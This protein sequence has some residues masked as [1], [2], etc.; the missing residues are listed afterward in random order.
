M[1]LNKKLSIF[2]CDFQIATF[3]I[4]SLVFGATFT[5]VPETYWAYSAIENVTA[6]GYLKDLK[7]TTFGPDNYIDKFTTSKIL[8]TVMN[9]VD[10][11]YTA[12]KE[13]ISVYSGKF[14]KWNTDSNNQIAYLLSKNILLDEDIA[15]FMLFSDDGSEKFRAISREEVAVLLVR[16]IGKTDEASKMQNSAF[17]KDN[18]SI[19]E[20]RKGSINYLKSI[21]VLNGDSNGN[22]NPKHAVTKAEFCVLL[23]NVTEKFPI[24]KNTITTPINNVTTVTGT[25]N[26]YYSAL[27]VVQLKVNNEVNTYRLNA[28]VT[29]TLENVETTKDAIVSSLN[30]VALMNNG[31][32]IELKLTKEPVQNTESTSVSDATTETTTLDS[33]TNSKKTLCLDTSAKGTIES[34]ALSNHALAQCEIGIFADSE[35][36]YFTATRYT[37]PIYELKIGDVVSVE[38]KDGKIKTLKFNSKNEK[39]VLTGYI[40]EIDDESVLV[41]SFNSD[42]YEFF[43]DE[44]YTECFDCTTGKKVDFDDLE[45]YSKVYIYYEDVN[46]RIIDVIFVLDN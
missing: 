38:A 41:E 43:Y 25:V 34:I 11:D 31:E 10:G 23:S 44:D 30:A 33:S 16:I 29:V 46:S 21:N 26:E 20:S 22:C 6:K 35:M 19:T 18:A 4:S 7:S 14:K 28:N 42:E 2:L 32:I 40:N 9:Y 39:N 8:A 13:R 36:K 3:S 15:N 27:N 37:A 1:K 5:D 24:T 12:E 17:F 45:K